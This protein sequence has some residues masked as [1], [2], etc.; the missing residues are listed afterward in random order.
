MEGP[1]MSTIMVDDQSVRIPS[2][3]SDLASFRRWYYSNDFPGEGRICFINGE[4]WVDM[5]REQFAHNQIKGQYTAVLTMLT[6]GTGI[7]RFF[8]DGYR[9]SNSDVFLSV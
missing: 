4:V 3:V 8:P 6:M 2:W 5:S 7:G 1:V 9:L